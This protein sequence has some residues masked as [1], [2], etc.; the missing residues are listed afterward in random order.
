MVSRE[1][2]CGQQEYEG[3]ITPRSGEPQ[4]HAGLR[5]RP[6]GT[7]VSGRVDPSGN[8]AF[9]QVSTLRPLWPSLDPISQIPRQDYETSQLHKA[10]VVLCAARSRLQGTEV[11]QPSKQPLNLPASLVAPEPAAVLGFGLFLLR[12]CGAIGSMPFSGRS[13][14]KLAASAAS[15]SVDSCEE[16][17]AAHTARERPV[18]S[19]SAMS[20]VPLPCLDFPP[21]QP[22]LG[23]HP[24]PRAFSTT[25]SASNRASS[26]SVSFILRSSSR[27][28]A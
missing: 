15:T 8:G 2:L 10:E 21:T 24:L 5:R 22:L 9:Q 12:L 6:V 28:R 14:R 4:G 23:A 19:V 13:R 27:S 25:S 11:T 1:D 26:S 18:A 17:L 16:A 7:V 3:W 20:S